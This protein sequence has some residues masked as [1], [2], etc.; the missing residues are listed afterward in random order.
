LAEYTFQPSR[1]KFSRIS[2]VGTKV[3]LLDIFGD[4][5]VEKTDGVRLR[6]VSS[7]N[8]FD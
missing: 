7:V 6:R 5:D 3:Y 8:I 2:I 1:S 4:G